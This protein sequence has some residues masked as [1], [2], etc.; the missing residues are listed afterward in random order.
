[1]FLCLRGG[2]LGSLRSDSLHS[3]RRPARRRPPVSSCGPGRGFPVHFFGVRPDGVLCLHVE[4]LGALD[5]HR[6]GGRGLF[7]LKRF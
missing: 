5:L 1:M 7:T 2:Q 3:V 6:R 4:R